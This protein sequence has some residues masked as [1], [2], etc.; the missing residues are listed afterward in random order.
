VGDV[1]ADP[2]AQAIPLR[3]A[4][5]LPPLF[6]IPPQV[7]L[8]W[9]YSPLLRQIP[10]NRPIWGMQATGFQNAEMPNTI[11][12]MA[13]EYV[14]QIRKIQPNG[15]YHLV[16]WSFGGNVAHEMARHLRCQG[17]VVSLLAIIDSAP[18]APP[19]STAAPQIPIW[20]KSLLMAMGAS[21]DLDK[22]LQAVVVRNSQ[23]IRTISPHQYTGD[24]VLFVSSDAN[25]QD[26]LNVWQPFVAGQIRSHR[27]G[28]RHDEMLTKPEAAAEIGRVLAVELCRPGAT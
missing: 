18:T 22:T 21:P 24:V 4:G 5:E 19:E 7:G 17:D 9:C 8:S 28:A 20:E 23:L 2:L 25:S 3:S 15:P 12:E 10:P 11:S 16:G 27:I 6:C 26:A 1:S 13:V 14:R